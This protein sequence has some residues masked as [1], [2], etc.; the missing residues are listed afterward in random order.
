MWDVN[1]TTQVEFQSVRMLD[2][3]CDVDLLDY[4]LQQLDC[5]CIRLNVLINFRKRCLEELVKQ[6]VFVCIFIPFLVRTLQKSNVI[7]CRLI[8]FRRHSSQPLCV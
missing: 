5:Q 8:N 6:L 2:H 4:V 3:A 7:K 1:S